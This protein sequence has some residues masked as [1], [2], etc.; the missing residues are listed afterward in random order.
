M[1]E[2][3]SGR[4]VPANTSILAGRPKRMG[5]AVIAGICVA[6]A[7]IA[8]AA[9]VAMLWCHRGQ[10]HHVHSP[11]VRC[12]RFR[13]L[14]VFSL[15]LIRFRTRAAPTRTLHALHALHA[16]PHPRAWQL[17]ASVA[18]QARNEPARLCVRLGR[19]CPRDAALLVLCNC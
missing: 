5:A 8:L 4:R 1:Q 3:L 16:C 7:S 9:V 13:S 12:N 14:R 2:L 17:P 19:S 18:L 6:S 11:Q 10:G 15:H